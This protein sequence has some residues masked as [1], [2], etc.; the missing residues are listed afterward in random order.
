[1]DPR[2]GCLSWL[3]WVLWYL[4]YPDQALQRSQE[5]CLLARDLELATSEAAAQHF[6]AAVHRL[7]RDAR[8]VLELEEAVIVIATKRESP[9]WLASA[10]FLRG[11]ALAD[12][13]NFEEGIAAMLQGIAGWRALGS[14]QLGQPTTMLADMYRRAGKAAEGLRLIA[15]AMPELQRSGERWWEAELY[16][17]EG[18][19]LFASSDSGL[20]PEVEQCFHKAV[21]TSRQQQAKSL[22]LRATMS[23][24]RLWQQQGKTADAHRLLTGIYSW[25]TEGFTTGDL[26]EAKTLLEELR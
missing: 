6:A 20:E 18:E 10:T 21:M 5:A 16:R 12:Q 15:T 8:S 3:A 24:C 7:C 14:D 26:Q 4:G 22:E 1:M 2:V 19:L 25:F 13:G 23:L 17:I 9:N 11:W